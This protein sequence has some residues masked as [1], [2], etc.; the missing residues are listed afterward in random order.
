MV[1]SIGDGDIVVG[2]KTVIIAIY[3]SAPPF[4]QKYRA[5][6]WGH[7]TEKGVVGGALAKRKA[8]KDQRQQNAASSNKMLLHILKNISQ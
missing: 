6:L 5:E 3:N 8:E 7:Q 4:P 1:K 2:I